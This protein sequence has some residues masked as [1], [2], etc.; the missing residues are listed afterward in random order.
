MLIVNVNDRSHD[1][2]AGDDDEAN[3]CSQFS[4]FKMMRAV[5][6]VSDFLMLTVRV[7]KILRHIT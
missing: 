6:R 7:L 1:Y 5:L 2:D 3:V 4:Q